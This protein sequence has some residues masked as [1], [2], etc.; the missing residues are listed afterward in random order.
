MDPSEFIEVI[1]G[2]RSD[3]RII[4]I[5]KGTSKEERKKI[6]DSLHDIGMS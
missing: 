2:I 4:K 6:I 5:G 1:I 3:H